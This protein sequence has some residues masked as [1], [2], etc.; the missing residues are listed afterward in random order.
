MVDSL[1]RAIAAALKLPKNTTKAV[2]TLSCDALPV[3]EVTTIALPTE[4][5][6]ELVETIEKFNLEMKETEK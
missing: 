5:N 1:T 6:R 3:I 2:I 4:E